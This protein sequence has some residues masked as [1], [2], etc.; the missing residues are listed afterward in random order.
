MSLANLFY[1][2]FRLP[3]PFSL[4]RSSRSP[5]DLAVVIGLSGKMIRTTPGEVPLLSRRKA[6]GEWGPW[7]NNMNLQW[8]SGLLFQV[9]MFRGVW[10]DKALFTNISHSI[11]LDRRFHLTLA[12][13]GLPF[14]DSYDSSDEILTLLFKCIYSS[15]FFFF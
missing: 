2:S 8:R 5:A 13:T 1:G 10:T 14:L 12:M 9:W 7:E 11:L 4:I 6:Y 3:C 15:T